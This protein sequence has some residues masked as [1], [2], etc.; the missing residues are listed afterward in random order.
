M[1]KTV[2]TAVAAAVAFGFL[3]SSPVEAKGFSG[4]GYRGGGF[5]S[6]AFRPAAPAYRPAPPA[7]AAP[8]QAAAPAPAPAPKQAVPAN[9]SGNNGGAKLPPASKGSGGGSSGPT[10]PV[11]RFGADRVPVSSGNNWLLWYLLLSGSNNHAVASS[12]TATSASPANTDVRS[13]I[14]DPSEGQLAKDW[15]QTCGGKPGALY[16]FNFKRNCEASQNETAKS[17]IQRCATRYGADW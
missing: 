7:P 15:V 12:G 14:C 9:G 10:G 16:H 6:P 17:W 4:G 3:A 11:S 8:K 1:R 2:V 5:S 13:F